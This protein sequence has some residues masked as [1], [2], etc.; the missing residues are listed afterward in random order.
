[1]PARAARISATGLGRDRTDADDRRL[2]AGAV[3]DGRGR[4]ARGRPAIEHEVDRVAELRHDARR[5]GASGTPERFADVVGSGPTPRARA[6]GASWSG[7]RRPIVGAA[8]GQHR[9]PRNVGALRDD[10]RQAAGPARRRER[11]RSRG[12]PPGPGRLGH[13]VEQQHHRLVRWT[14]LDAVQPLD[15]RR[16]WPA[17][18]R[19]RRPCRSAARRSPPSRSTSTATARPCASSATTRAVT[20]TASAAHRPR[21]PAAATPRGPRPGSRARAAR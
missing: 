8:A 4:A 21:R 17:T 6:R 3:D 1:M 5:V 2:R 9:R 15:A 14:P 18:R 19:C 16:A 11:G 10:D 13:V 12:D 20:R 7:T